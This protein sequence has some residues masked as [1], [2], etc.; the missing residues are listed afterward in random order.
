MSIKQIL[1]LNQFNIEGKKHENESRKCYDG[2]WWWIKYR[3]RKRMCTYFSLS[4]SANVLCANVLATNESDGSQ[5]T[6][7][8]FNIKA[9][10]WL[11]EG[12]FN[13]LPRFK[14]HH[15]ETIS[16][17]QTDTEWTNSSCYYQLDFIVCVFIQSTDSKLNSFVVGF[18]QLF[19]VP[20][21]KIGSFFAGKKKN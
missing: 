5:V 21:R 18:W 2:W 7:N 9:F 11:A 3:Y 20:V 19:S 16:D 15:L 10:L 8:S 17:F 6:S 12:S 14:T 1:P 4:S 13:N